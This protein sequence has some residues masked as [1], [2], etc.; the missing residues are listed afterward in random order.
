MLMSLDYKKTITISIFAVSV[1]LFFSAMAC[2]GE[3]NSNPL[4]VDDCLSLAR[5]NNETV[6]IQFR[7]ITQAE[8]RISQASGAALPNLSVTYQKYFR[9]TANDAVSGSGTDSKFYAE[10]ALYNGSRIQKG[11]EL[12]MSDKRIA[13]LQLQD[14]T[15]KLDSDVA[16]AFYALAQAESDYRNIGETLGIMTDRKTELSERVRL[17]K[18]R[19]SEL[20]MLESQIAILLSD[21]RKIS[22][23]RAKSLESLSFLISVGTP[24]IIISDTAPEPLFAE[25]TDKL[26]RNSLSR[27]DVEAAKESVAGQ[28]LRLKMAK[29]AYFPTFDVN[30][31]WYLARSGSPTDLK[32]DVYLM[33]NAPIYQGGIAKARVKEES[34]KLEESK[35]YSSLVKREL[36]T[37]IRQLCSLLE[38]SIAQVSALRDAYGKARKSYD[39]QLNDYRL[40]L[41]NNLDVIQATLT[42]LDVKSRLDCAVLQSKLDKSLL[43]IAVK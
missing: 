43:D 25:P 7:K 40:G 8:H 2:S 17:G 34:S 13:D 28:S 9:D 38:S 20:Y 18:S 11:I 22:G 1:F 5:K 23:D 29:G 35:E 31:S 32:W 10:E 42:L 26:I 36:E 12:S 30:S 14:I 33:L 39:L 4:T 16:S 27:S 15:R 19:E 41:V 6:Q 21:L 3:Q 24:S 37:E